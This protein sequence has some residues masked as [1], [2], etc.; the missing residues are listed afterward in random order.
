MAIVKDKQ[1][2]TFHFVNGGFFKIIS[3]IFFCINFVCFRI[4]FHC[5]SEYFFVSILKVL[6]FF[7]LDN[8][9]MC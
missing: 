8:L 7:H 2:T 4:F 6:D 1:K 5:F 9:I 3:L